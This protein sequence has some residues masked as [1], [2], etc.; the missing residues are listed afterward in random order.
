[1]ERALPKDKNLLELFSRCKNKGLIHFTTI[2]GFPI[3]SPSSQMTLCFPL[4]DSH[5][6]VQVCAQVFMCTHL[7]MHQKHVSAHE[8]R[9]NV[10]LRERDFQEHI[11][12]C[13]EIYI[14]KAKMFLWYKCYP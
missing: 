9:I 2:F 14:L 1:M 13:E 6:E 3:F 10:R 8:Q 12:Q 11:K 4:V 7:Y 5:G